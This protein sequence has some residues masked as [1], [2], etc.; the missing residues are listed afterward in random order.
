MKLLWSFACLSALSLTGCGAVDEVP[1]GDEAPIQGGHIDT[2][3]PAVGMLW[4]EGGGF[5]SGVL[6]S[7]TI[8]LTAGHC[9][10]KPIEG[11]YTGAGKKALSVG[12]SPVSGMQRH[13]VN[14][15]ISHPSYSSH[16]GCPNQTFD[17]GL[18]RLSKPLTSVKPSALA[19]HA[20]SLGQ[21]CRIVGYGLHDTAAGVESFEQKRAAN[22]KIAGGGTTWVEVTW[23]S[24][25][26][27][28]GDSGGPLLCS[29]KI[30]AVTSCGTDGVYPNH[31]SSYYA[32]VD[33]IG[34]WIDTTIKKWK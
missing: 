11:F 29:D 2:D 10:A 30:A 4:M 33:D 18:V 14:A 16:G 8:V 13:A 1:A 26:S 21:S 24:G 7:P 20:P 9:V 12:E 34:G 23:Q 5:C 28:H 25:I 19:V 17:V 6:I 15:Q 31:R 32:R 27:D 22:V 3:D